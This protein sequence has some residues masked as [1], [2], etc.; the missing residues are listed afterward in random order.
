[1]AVELSK[2]KYQS[3]RQIK[4]Q[5]ARKGWIWSAAAAVLLILVL[6]VAAFLA[7]PVETLGQ[8]AS[9]PKG[10]DIHTFYSPT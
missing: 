3:K 7:R 6:G 9:T 4:K 8:T 5:P 2:R 10:G 1:L